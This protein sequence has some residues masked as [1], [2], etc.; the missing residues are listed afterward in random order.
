MPLQR[1]VGNGR[2]NGVGIG[3]AVADDKYLFF[4]GCSMFNLL[5][6]CPGSIKWRCT[7]VKPAGAIRHPPFSRDQQKNGAPHCRGT[8]FLF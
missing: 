4:H 5:Q 3:I 2:S 8:P 6:L 1:R 7:I